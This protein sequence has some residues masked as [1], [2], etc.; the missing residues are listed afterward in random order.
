[1]TVKKKKN[2]VTKRVRAIPRL[3]KACTMT[4]YSFENVSEVNAAIKQLELAKGKKNPI[5]KRRIEIGKSRVLGET[6]ATEK[7][8]MIETPA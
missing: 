8:L 6:V 1:M 4:V 3:K 5:I 7:P 2:A